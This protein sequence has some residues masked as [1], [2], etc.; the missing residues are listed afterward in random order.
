MPRPTE[1]EVLALLIERLVDC[2]DPAAR[3][4]LLVEALL[5][6]DWAQAAALYPPGGDPEQAPW[7]PRI[8]RGPADLLPDGEVVRAVASGDLP[9]ELPLGRRVLFAPGASCAL[10][11]GGYQ[12]ETA[13][14]DHLEALLAAASVIEDGAPGEVDLLDRLHAPFGAAEDGDGLVLEPAATPARGAGVLRPPLGQPGTDL[15]ALLGER[16]APWFWALAQ[17]GIDLE[18]VLDAESSQRRAPVERAAL[19][20]LLDEVLDDNLAR[21]RADATGPGRVRLDLAWEEDGY[22]LRL[23]SDLAAATPWHLPSGP[24]LAASGATSRDHA[25]VLELRLG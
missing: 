24:R 22:L 18:L 7:L 13:D 6:R 1:L 25:G 15:A 3:E 16:C 2:P 20:G 4:R 10:A 23:S 5:E 12:G 14:L 19:E 21:L 17:R 8:A 11:L 9:E